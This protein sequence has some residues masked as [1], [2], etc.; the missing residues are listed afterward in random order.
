MFFYSQN[1]ENNGKLKYSLFKIRLIVFT[2]AYKL[3]IFEEKK[4]IFCTATYD[5]INQESKGIER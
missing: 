5:M 1:G 2:N 4:N 3:E